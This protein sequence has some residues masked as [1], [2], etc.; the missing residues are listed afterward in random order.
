M[1]LEKDTEI[2]TLTARFN[3]ESRRR[4]ENNETRN[5]AHAVRSRPQLTPDAKWREKDSKTGFYY[6]LPLFY[7]W[8]YPRQKQENDLRYYACEGDDKKLKEMLKKDKMI[9]NGRGVPD[10]LG[11]LA[12][13]W[14]DK[15]A[16]M[17]ASKHGH[18]NC[19]KTL[20]KNSADVHYLDRDKKTALDHAQEYARTSYNTEIAD[21]LIEKGAVN[22]S[23]LLKD[24]L[25]L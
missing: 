9:V 19:V 14:E 11:S 7:T 25:K 23:S 17:L 13:S 21:F 15:T 16:L 5:V 20:V 12:K 8:W 4:T 10:S 1:I 6:T 3:N 22:G 24:A 2:N 18:F